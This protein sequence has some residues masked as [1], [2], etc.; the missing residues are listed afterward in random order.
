MYNLVTS[1]GKTKDPVSDCG[2]VLVPLGDYDERI[3]MS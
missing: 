2:G 3:S 1:Q